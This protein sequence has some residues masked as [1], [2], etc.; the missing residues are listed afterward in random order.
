MV[1][2]FAIPA[3][4]LIFFTI[5]TLIVLMSAFWI[6]MIIDCAK[7]NFKKE[8]DKVVWI[9]ILIF[10]GVIGAIIYYFVVKKE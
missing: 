1:N 9:I 10:A 3:I 2:A 5:L 7:R 8:N 6:W 4:I